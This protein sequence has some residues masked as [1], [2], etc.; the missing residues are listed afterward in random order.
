[1][2]AWGFVHSNAVTEPLSLTVLDVS[3]IAKE[4][5][6]IRA[7]AAIKVIAAVMIAAHVLLRNEPDMGDLPLPQSLSNDRCALR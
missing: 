3:N 6:A 2:Y 5:W 7:V 1:M 4:W